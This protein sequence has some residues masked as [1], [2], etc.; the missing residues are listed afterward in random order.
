[1]NGFII[2]NLDRGLHTSARPRNKRALAEYHAQIHHQ[3][4]FF[5]N[6]QF[7]EHITTSYEVLYYSDPGCLTNK[8]PKYTWL[9]MKQKNCWKAC[10]RAQARARTNK[11]RP[12]RPVS[13][14]KL[15]KLDY[16]QELNNW[17]FCQSSSK[18]GTALTVK[19]AGPSCWLSG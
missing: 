18:V 19:L 15:R 6:C 4:L 16:L 7:I 3:N 12:V 8:G 10:I 1:M 14:I 2:D 13:W 11:T 17:L 9:E 5:T